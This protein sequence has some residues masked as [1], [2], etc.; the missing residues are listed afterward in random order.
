M[1]ETVRV[2][3]V[4]HTPQEKD[5]IELL[6]IEAA[7]K[8]NQTKTRLKWIRSFINTQRK[9]TS[10]NKAK[11]QVEIIPV[12]N[13]LNP[14]E[15]LARLSEIHHILR[16]LIVTTDDDVL[17]SVLAVAASHKIMDATPAWLMLV[18][19]SSGGKT[20]NIDLLRGYP[21]VYNIDILTQNTFLSGLEAKKSA[22]G[23]D[24]SLLNRYPNHIYTFKD[25]TEILALDPHTRK[26]IFGQLRGI[27]DGHVSK[28]TGIGEDRIWEGHI[29]AIAG[30]T[31]EIYKYFGAINAL[32]PR[33]F[34]I[35]MKQAD[36]DEQAAMA[37]SH[38]SK[39][40]KSLKQQL[41]DKVA[42]F[43]SALSN[44]EPI[45]REEDKEWVGALGSVVA[46]GRSTVDRDK[47]GE[48][49]GV[50]QD[51]QPGRITKQLRTFSSG[52]ALIHGHQT[53]ENEDLRV[54][55][56]IG[57]DTIPPERHFILH[58]L[59]KT[60]DLAAKY[61][62][63][64]SHFSEDAI[65]DMLEEMRWLDLVQYRQ[66]VAAREWD[67]SPYVRLKFT[68]IY[69]RFPLTTPN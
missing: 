10:K 18:G 2:W 44:E 45:L 55:L 51:E 42:L 22:N 53:I 59:F 65:S 31:P 28:P 68:T 11:Q 60:P 49:K 63:E 27:H 67:L 34:F 30:V 23:A 56:R 16:T 5:A 47:N 40:E 35:R 3:K 7:E 1:A 32:G 24:P 57:M 25:F 54:T 29:T 61:L 20:E 43:L 17:D 66:G 48:I 46:K 36:R 41:R 9:K 39:E 19:G 38:T 15:A 21:L 6:I 62:A 69:G 37:L 64:G 13:P 52:M 33:F 50:S 8:S 4:A 12:L 14:D 58:K 26:N